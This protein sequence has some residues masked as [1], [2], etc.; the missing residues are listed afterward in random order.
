MSATTLHQAEVTEDQ[1]PETRIRIEE[2]RLSGDYIG[3]GA[4]QKL[5]TTV[6]VRKPD[7]Q[8]FIRT[9]SDP[10]YR[11]DTYTLE[12]KEER[13]TYLVTPSLWPELLGE[14]VPK[15]IFTGINCRGVVFLWP[16]RLP[17]EDGRRDA[18]NESA[19]QAAEL[20]MGNWVRVV[21]NMSLG[22]YDIYQAVGDIPEPVWPEKSFEELVQVAFK[23]LYIDTLDHPVIRQLQG[24][25]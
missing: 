20:A 22:G 3:A 15:T 23:H 2:Q 17:G 4:T 24:A 7:R 11:L 21:S 16:V 25:V 8:W 6:P 18:W 12:L 14:I 10:A 5:V 19:L 1:Q 9:S 13:E